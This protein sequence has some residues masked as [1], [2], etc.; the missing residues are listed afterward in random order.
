MFFFLGWIWCMTITFVFI[1]VA[2]KNTQTSQCCCFGA[3]DKMHLFHLGDQK[4]STAG[5]NMLERCLST[6]KTKQPTY[7]EGVEN[8]SQSSSICFIKSREKMLK[9]WHLPRAAINQNSCTKMLC[10][11]ASF[12][13]T[14]KLKQTTFSNP[15]QRSGHVKGSVGQWV[16]NLNG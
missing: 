3:F 7:S 1:F 15:S 4:I 12:D 8:L 5:L 11:V 10:S 14:W 2:L 13:A 16:M 9:C 6:S